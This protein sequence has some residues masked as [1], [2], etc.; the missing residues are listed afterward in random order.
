LPQQHLILGAGGI[1]G[2][3]GTLLAE[4]GEHVT[5]LVRQES[6][7]TMPE[8]WTAIRPDGATHSAKISKA[9]SVPANTAVD[10]L[11]V[12]TKA[13]QLDGALR[14]VDRLRPRAVV[15]LL[16]G[17]EHIGTLD[18]LFG[19]DVVFPS[20]IFVESERI[21]PGSVIQRS[22]FL[23]FKF[24]RRGEELISAAARRL[25][26]RDAEIEFLADE[27][28]LLWSKL[29]FLAPFALTTTA[30]K[31]PAAFLREQPLWRERFDAAV[32]EVVT[33]GRSLG[34][35][36][37]STTAQALL[38]RAKPEMR[39]SMLK[40]AVAGRELEL[41]AIAGSVIRCADQAGIPVPTLRLLRDLIAH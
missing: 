20:T 3:I 35:V 22:P 32:D 26:E 31:E 15:P 19:K 27:T 18:G 8:T 24:A 17:L 10:V 25:A 39:S 30:A 29:V 11:W 16:N 13:T 12:T 37:E 5:F 41:D 36:L 2:L 14:S 1:G 28:T 21:A 38:G 33:V 6:F 7:E 40:D 23:I 34:A 4:S 9:T